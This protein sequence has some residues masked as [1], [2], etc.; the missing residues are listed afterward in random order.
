LAKKVRT[1]KPPR[2]AGAGQRPVQAPKKRSG[3]SRTAKVPTSSVGGRGY[4][5]PI[6]AVVVGLIIVGSVLGIVLTRSSTSLAKAPLALNKPISW[7]DLPA[8][9]TGPPPW[10]N[11]GTTLSLRLPSL[12]LNQLGQEQLAFHI[13][14]HLD[15]FID[16][17][18]VK[19]P[20]AIGFGID[21]QTG[22]PAYITELHT[23]NALGIVHVESAQTLRYQ[24]GQFFGEWGVRLTRTCI[25]NFKGGCGLQWYLNGKRQTGDPAK[26]VLKNHEEIAIVVGKPPKTIPSTFDW[27]ANGI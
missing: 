12:G 8:M 7:K 25:G 22:K 21:P 26:L 15:I 4:F 27:S 23:H 10:N 3:P 18:P 11:G 20:Q 16:G 6:A 14:Q 9:Q 5:W 17:K 19:V 13:H 1:P 2:P 24:L